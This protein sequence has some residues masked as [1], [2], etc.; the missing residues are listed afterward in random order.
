MQDMQ[1]LK[2]KLAIWV[3]GA[4]SIGWSTTRGFKNFFFFKNLGWMTIQQSVAY[5]S[6]RM[7]IKVMQNSY[8]KDL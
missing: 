4:I 5:R 6:I 1:Y 8:P 7:G 3:L 2:V